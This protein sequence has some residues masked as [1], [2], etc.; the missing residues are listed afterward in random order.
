[1]CN[2][3]D[4]IDLLGGTVSVCKA[5]GFLPARVSN[6]RIRGIPADVLIDNGSFRNELIRVGYWRLEA[7]KAGFKSVVRHENLHR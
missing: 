5:F 1:M 3:S 6:W 2:A 4:A 7:K